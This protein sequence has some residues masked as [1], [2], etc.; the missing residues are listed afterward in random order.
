MRQY[1]PLI[2]M[3]LI[4]SIVTNCSRKKEITQKPNV[5]LIM[6]DDIG[7]ECLSINGSKSYN[8]PVLDSLAANG[9]NFT[10][11]IS[12]PLCTPSRVKIMTGKYNFRNYEHF[13]YLNSNQKTFGNLFRENGY[14]T[15]AIGKWHLGHKKQYLPL[16]H[17]F[18]YY[19]GIPYSNDMENINGGAIPVKDYYWKIY[20][21]EKPVSDN[22]KV[23]LLENNETIERPADQTTITKRYT[24]K[25]VEYIRKNLNV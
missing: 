24:E 1:F 5:I 13:T 14:K 19:Y 9:I 3:I 25:A 23:P 20:D 18:D 2:L 10:N 16:Q 7:F 4:S 8:T 11:T 6:A 12:Q 22:Y 15:A 21:S 17:G